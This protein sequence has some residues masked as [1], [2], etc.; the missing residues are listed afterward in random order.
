LSDTAYVLYK[1]SS[2]YYPEFDSGIIWND[3][4]LNI[5]WPTS[6]PILSIKDQNL[7][8]SKNNHYDFNF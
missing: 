3:A 5:S 8:P 4:E 1:V 7:L 2:N 6:D